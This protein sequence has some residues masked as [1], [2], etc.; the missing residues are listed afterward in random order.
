M[1][2]LLKEIN[3]AVDLM[4]DRLES[5]QG[6]RTDAMC[7]LSLTMS[8]ALLSHIRTLE[9]ELARMRDSMHWMDWVD[10]VASSAPDQPAALGP[11][12]RVGAAEDREPSEESS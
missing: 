3:E 8:E 10:G 12:G 11:L 6:R 1:K 9:E 5:G 4:R 7:R 2:A